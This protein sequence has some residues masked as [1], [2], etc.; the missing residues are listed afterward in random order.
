MHSTPASI[1]TIMWVAYNCVL[2]KII[3]EN[4]IKIG[5]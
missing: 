3:L 4:H 1:T 2:R 5:T